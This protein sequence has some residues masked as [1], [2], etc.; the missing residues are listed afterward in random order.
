M[1]SHSVVNGTCGRDIVSF[2]TNAAK[3]SDSFSSFVNALLRLG[4]TCETDMRAPLC[5]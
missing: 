2:P 1:E 5:V 3:S 4:P